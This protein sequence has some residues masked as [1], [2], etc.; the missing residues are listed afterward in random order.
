MLKIFGK[1]THNFENKQTNP[2]N[3]EECTF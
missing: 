2:A 3:Y 1:D